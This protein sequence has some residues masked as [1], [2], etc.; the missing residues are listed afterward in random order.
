MHIPPCF[1]TYAKNTRKILPSA[2]NILPI[3]NSAGVVNTSWRRGD[4]LLGTT[5]GGHNGYVRRSEADRSVSGGGAPQRSAPVLP[6]RDEGEPSRWPEGA[7]GAGVDG[8]GY[9]VPHEP[10]RLWAGAGRPDQ[11]VGAEYLQGFPEGCR[12]IT[13]GPPPGSPGGG[14][15]QGGDK[16]RY[17]PLGAIILSLPRLTP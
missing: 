12:R 5:L 10:E 9:G 14:F 2:R 13:Q 3:A 7:A 16:T 11:V 1:I 4:G 17:M 8:H 6:A 15:L